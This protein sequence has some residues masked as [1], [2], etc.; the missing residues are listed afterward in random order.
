MA[1]INRVISSP[2]TAVYRDVQG[3]VEYVYNTAKWRHSMYGTTKT[4][5][6]SRVKPTPPN[7]YDLT[8]K[9]VG[10]EINWSYFYPATGN[11]I[12]AR[13][14]GLSSGSSLFGWDRGETFVDE[15]WD[16]CYNRA[17]D[18]FNDKYRGNLD[19][20]VDVAEAG[21]T[22]KM[23]K[24]TDQVVDFTKTFVQRF[25]VVK[26]ASK[27]W[28]TY[29]Y[30]VRPLLSSIHGLA[31]E[32]IRVVLNRTN[33]FRV[34][35]NEQISDCGPVSVILFNGPH[36]GLRTRGSGKASVTVS[37]WLAS[38]EV[39]P[40]RFTSLNPVSLAWEFLPFSFV[41]DWFYNVGGYLRNMETALVYDSQF[42]S[43]YVTKLWAYDGMIDHLDTGSNGYS[44][45]VNTWRGR[46]KETRIIRT[47]IYSYPRPTPPSFGAQLG[48][49]RLLSAASLLGTMLG[50][51]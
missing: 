27:A 30:G 18:G 2:S 32:N 45:W 7:N 43:G 1:N 40:G 44:S 33:K 3:G 48:S 13:G 9:L 26:V 39:D 14:D 6:K 23:L 11:R 4:G 35:R 20:S 46:L 34:R 47:V 31:E 19:L 50:R 42:R 15:A 10:C 12:I 51:R 36:T 49:S 8:V 37:A 22:A 5:P 16:R 28:L 17:L 38:P 24:L 21:K 25:G 41:A 29:M